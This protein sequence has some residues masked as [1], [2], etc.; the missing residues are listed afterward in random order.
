LIL[1]VGVAAV[2]LSRTNS[3]SAHPVAGDHWHAALGVYLCD[4]WQGDGNWTWPAQTPQGSPAR[5]GTQAYAGLHSHGDGIIHIEPQ[6]SDEMGK[7][8]TVGTYF[9]FGGWKLSD[10]QVEFVGESKKNGDKCGAKPGE[11]RWEVNGVEKTGNPAHYK[12]K[13]GDEIAIAFVPADLSL[14]TLGHV[15]SLQHLADALNRETNTPL[16]DATTMPTVPPTTKAGT[17]TTK[18][19]TSST[20]AKTPPSS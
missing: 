1:I 6:T 16:P 20:T 4:H 19:A 17:T 10:K 7:N 9:K 12:I 15:P 3:A 2:A 11:I 14:K 18:P 13:D 5:F 8:A